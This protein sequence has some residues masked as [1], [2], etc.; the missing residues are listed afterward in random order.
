[1][2]AQ[3]VLVCACYSEIISFKKQQPYVQA[4]YYATLASEKP[5]FAY[6]EVLNELDSINLDDY[7]PL[8][9]AVLSRAHGVALFEGNF[10]ESQVPSLVDSFASH[11]DFEPL[12]QEEWPEVEIVQLPLAPAGLGSTIVRPSLNPDDGGSAAVLAF[13]IG[14]RR[15]ESQVLSELFGTLVEQPFYESL[16]TQQQLGYLVFSGSRKRLGIS[17]ILFIVQSSVRDPL[18]CANRML[19]FLGEFMAVLDAMPEQEFNNVVKGLV[20]NK[21]QP[22]QRL[23][24]DVSRHWEELISGELQFERRRDEALAL[25]KLK[26]ADVKRFFEQFVCEGGSE[27]RCLTSLLVSPNDKDAVAA[28]ALGKGTIEDPSRWRDAQ[29]VYPKRSVL[30]RSTS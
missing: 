21:L 25:K 27:R 28:D 23:A 17:S 22:S 26:K 20:D 14:D 30:R 12:P 29:Q 3:P 5:K 15:I 24:E 4:I 19:D 18:Y 8:L 13:Q 11:F 6:E 16:R 2:R 7:G 9:K 10:F 1:M